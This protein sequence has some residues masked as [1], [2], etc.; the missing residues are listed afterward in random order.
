MCVCMTINLILIDPGVDVSL[1][2]E[3]LTVQLGIDQVPLPR[4][5]PAKVLDGHL[6][7]TVTHQTMPIHM[8]LSSSHHE[9][10]QF[11]ILKSPYLPL[12]LGYP[13]LRC[14][15]PHIDW[16]TGSIRGWSSS[17]GSSCWLQLGP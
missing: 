15:N 17:T 8:L 3:D 6:L 5:V 7:G 4:P 1:N 9:T 11:H 10:I 16:A 12:I 14:H 13:W 2:D